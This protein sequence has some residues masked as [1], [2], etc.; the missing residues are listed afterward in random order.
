MTSKAPR[1]FRFLTVKQIK[2]LHARKVIQ[3]G[4]PTQPD[5][6]ESAA[7]SPI[8]VKNY[9]KVYNIFKLAANLSEKK[10]QESCISGWQ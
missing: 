3:S 9:G 8:N 6:L 1:T 4:L 10:N 7:N 2:R 5:L